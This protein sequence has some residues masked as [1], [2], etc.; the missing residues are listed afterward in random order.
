MTTR[1]ISI[2]SSLM[3][4]FVQS[5]LAWDSE[6]CDTIRGDG[7]TVECQCYH[8]SSF[9]VIEVNTGHSLCSNTQLLQSSA[10][11]KNSIPDQSLVQQNIYIARKDCHHSV[12]KKHHRAVY[13]VCNTGVHAYIPNKPE[14]YS[15][16]H[17]A[18]PCRF[19]E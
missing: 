10:M 13:C 12:S 8:L 14:A 2:L 15:S 18:F 6:G 16:M 19:L 1:E 7:D 3:P 17:H 9:A 5:F 4:F 11:G